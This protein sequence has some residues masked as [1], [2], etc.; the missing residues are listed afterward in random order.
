[1]STKRYCDACTK[2]IVVGQLEIL[3][4]SKPCFIESLFIY[5]ADDNDIDLCVEC[6]VKIIGC[7]KRASPKC[8]C[9]LSSEPPCSVCLNS[10]HQTKQESQSQ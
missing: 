6:A 7:G 8:Q 1:M 10:L 2:E 4:A 3:V 5:S 9:E